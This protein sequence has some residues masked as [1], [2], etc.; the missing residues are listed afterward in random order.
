MKVL[1]QKRF[2]KTVRFYKACFAFREPFKVLCDG[3]FL[4]FTLSQRLG[5]LQDALPSLLGAATKAFVTRCI[6][7]ELKQLG[8]S[9]SGTLLAA[10]RLEIAKCNHEPFKSASD[11]LGAM[12]GD[13]NPEHFF[14]ATQD[15]ELRKRFCKV[16]GV[17]LIFAK[18]NSLFLEPPSEWQQ[19]FSRLSEAERMHVKEQELK[20]IDFRAM[21]KKEAELIQNLDDSNHGADHT[22]GVS[23]KV[24][25]A[26]AK[27]E[28]F[29]QRRN[30]NVKERP[31]FKRK[32]AK[33]PNPLSCQKKQKKPVPG[34]GV[35]NHTSQ[36]TPHT[37]S[38][39]KR[40][41]RRNR[42][43]CSS[44]NIS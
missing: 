35:D 10:R 41:R 13:N 43:N 22:E 15:A 8:E 19:K 33:G 23:H 27:E 6:I 5:S 12:V 3:N 20:I 1:K 17:A 44:G 40:C 37:P 34:L 36:T 11:C 21:K 24:S 32:R 4:H 16:Y 28:T 31:V 39:R 38:R 29:E 25:S 26:L 7:A 2:R 9:F 42:H 30:L 18:K 14:I